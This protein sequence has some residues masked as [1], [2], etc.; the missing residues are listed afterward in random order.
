[1]N[2]IK[3]MALAFVLCS[4]VATSV[5]AEDLNKVIVIKKEIDPEIIGGIYVRIGNDVID[6]TLKTRLDELRKLALS[7]E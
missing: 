5:V 6:G 2:R 4:A 1:M 3:Y 7:M